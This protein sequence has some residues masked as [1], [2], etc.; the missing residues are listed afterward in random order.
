[1]AVLDRPGLELLKERRFRVSNIPPGVRGRPNP[2]LDPSP[3]RI[4]V[5]G[6]LL[7]SLDRRFGQREFAVSDESRRPLNG[8]CEKEIIFVPEDQVGDPGDHLML[9]NY[10]VEWQ[11]EQ[12]TPNAFVDPA[13]EGRQL[14]R[15]DDVLGYWPEIHHVL[16]ENFPR[17]RLSRDRALEGVGLDDIGRG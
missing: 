4:G 13:C 15:R 2:S 16:V 6:P 7:Q 11:D 10:P 9:G 17:Y 3:H 1:M 14:V 5:A 8:P 12:S